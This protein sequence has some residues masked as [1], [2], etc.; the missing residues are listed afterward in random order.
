M[1]ESETI[2]FKKSLAELSEGLNSV[3][4]ILNK[5]GGGELWFGIRNDGRPV[6][7]DVSETTLRKVS[8]AIAAHIEPKIY[9]EVSTVLLDGKS[10]IRVSFT[11]SQKPYYA[12]GRAYMRVADEDRQLSAK[13]IESIIL[14]KNRS[15]R[16]WDAEPI[17]DDSFKPDTA[18]L[19]A[20]VRK[21][22]LTWTNSQ[23]ALENLG[24]FVDG[25]HL[26]AAWVFFAKHPALTL[27]C[28]VFATSSTSTIIDQHDFTGDILTLIEEAEKYVL[29]NIRIGMR[30]EGLV[31]VDVPEI[32]R[33]AF[34]EAIINAFCH[35]DY[36][37]PDEVRIAIFPD[38]VEVRNP[39]TLMEGV[40]LKTLKTAKVSRRRNPL[41]ADLLRRIH[42]IEAWGRGIPLILEKAPNVRFSQ[43]AGIFITEFPRP[44]AV[45]N[46]ESGQLA[47]APVEAPVEAPVD[48]TETEQRILSA[49]K[50]QT[51][52]S[53]ELLTLLGYGQKTGNF[54]AAMD[55][56]F[57]L[58]LI[59]YT[60]PEKPNSRLQKYRL[61]P[62]GLALLH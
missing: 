29:K 7:M 17:Q 49:L 58:K 24:L 22:G 36:R 27:R 42:L 11:G 9:P 28:A 14:R 20:F 6:G 46:T 10:C 15:T 53:K 55:K 19:R 2:E 38:R 48:L 40:S 33:E 13:E 59:E 4:A 23:G 21:A 41:I 30:L 44:L 60:I 31:R 56:L 8:Q 52:G 3:A 47:G 43:V 57:A 18:K 35:R 61:N 1:Q 51:L 32:D 12:H 5:H 50:K 39:G 16:G 37:D 25:R 54:K 34:R 26:N 45:E 62:K